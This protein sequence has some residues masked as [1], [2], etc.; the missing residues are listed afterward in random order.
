MDC[1]ITTKNSYTQ[2]FSKENTFFRVFSSFCYL[3][4]AFLARGVGGLPLRRSLS[5]SGHSPSCPVFFSRIR[6]ILADRKTPPAHSGIKTA[7]T[8]LPPLLTLYCIIY[9]S[10]SSIVCLMLLSK[11]RKM[12][13][14][15]FA[16]RSATLSNFAGFCL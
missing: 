9:Q 10:S 3:Y 13:S 1:K 11:E 6:P 14:I 15:L 8:S 16:T 7:A 5:T 2:I 12:F 4:F